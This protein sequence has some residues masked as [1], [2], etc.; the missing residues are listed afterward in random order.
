M[1]DERPELFDASAEAM[2]YASTDLPSESGWPEDKGPAVTLPEDRPVRIRLTAH[3][4]KLAFF[5]GSRA[6][7]PFKLTI[8]RAQ[9]AQIVDI[10]AFPPPGVQGFEAFVGFTPESLALHRID[11]V[12]AG[13][14]NSA[15]RINDP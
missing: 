14:A 4:V 12:E 9:W 5:H 15:A 7:P 1:I 6:L 11:A 3:G 10:V 2:P 13:A 8:P